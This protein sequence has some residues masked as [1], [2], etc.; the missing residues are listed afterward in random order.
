[1][2]KLGMLSLSNPALKESSVRSAIREMADPGFNAWLA[3]ALTWSLA[4]QCLN[5]AA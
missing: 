3:A 1:M 4:L 2:N 5:E